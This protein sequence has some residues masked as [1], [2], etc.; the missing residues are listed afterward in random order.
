MKATI[1]ASRL[2]GHA[3]IQIATSMA[4]GRLPGTLSY[5]VC[6]ESSA[7]RP[8]L[9]SPLRAPDAQKARHTLLVNKL[10]G[11][12]AIS[13]LSG[14]LAADYSAYHLTTG[15]CVAMQQTSLRNQGCCTSR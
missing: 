4:T 11:S 10:S 3:V 12:A 9:P 15:D 1:S 2:L 8:P 14:S 13:Q 5:G 6:R 7:D